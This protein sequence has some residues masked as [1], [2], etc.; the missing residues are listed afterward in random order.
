MNFRSL[1]V[2]QN[3]GLS[4]S[5]PCAHIYVK[6]SVQAG[7]QIALIGFN[8]IARKKV[9]CNPKSN[10]KLYISNDEEMALVKASCFMA[11]SCFH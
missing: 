2:N 11:K 9:K 5:P 4:L 8:H 1:E 10:L 3:T 6:V 7:M